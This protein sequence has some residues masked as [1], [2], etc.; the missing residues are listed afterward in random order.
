MGRPTRSPRFGWVVAPIGLLAN[1]D[2]SSHRVD[3]PGRS[4]F[5]ND[6]LYCLRLLYWLGYYCPMTLLIFTHLLPLHAFLDRLTPCISYLISWLWAFLGNKLPMESDRTHFKWFPDKKIKT[7][8][9]C[10]K[11]KIFLKKIEFFNIFYFKL[12]FLMFSVCW[13]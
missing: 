7:C 10:F 5:N 6:G 8:L 1:P 9:C 11:I 4:R 2:Q 12:I 13:Y 3:P